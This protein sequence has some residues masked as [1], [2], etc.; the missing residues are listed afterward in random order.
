[1]SKPLSDTIELITADDIAATLKLSARH[2][3]ERLVKRP[4]FPPDYQ[5]IGA[6]R[7]DRKEVLHWINQQREK[8]T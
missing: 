8:H 2:V 1:M 4:G 7:W 5:I 6:R 3:R